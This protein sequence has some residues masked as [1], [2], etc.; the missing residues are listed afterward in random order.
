MKTLELFAGSRSFSKE[1][2]KLGYETYTTDINDFENIDQVCNIFDFEP[3]KVPFI[4]NFIWASPPCYT[5]SVASIGH[6]WTG[7]KG[8]YIPKTKE[9]VM[10]IKIAQKTKEIIDYYKSINPNLL[11]LVEN[12]RGVLRK[13][14]IFP[15]EELKTAWYCQYGDTRAKPTDLWTNFDWKPKTCKNGNPDC[16]HERAPRGSRT[17]TQGLKGNYERSMVPADLCKKIISKVE[18]HLF[19]LRHGK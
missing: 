14:D 17:G 13:L 6:H 16:D 5:F 11:Y 2:E 10:G 9:A 1:A 3:S 15:E 8:A 7:G 4:P 18:V 19:T 12:P